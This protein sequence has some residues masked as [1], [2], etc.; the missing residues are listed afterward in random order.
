MSED[1]IKTTVNQIMSEYPGYTK[2]FIFYWMHDMDIGKESAWAISHYNA[3]DDG[4]LQ[5]TIQGASDEEE[6]I[7]KTTAIPKGE[8][9]GRWFDNS[10][11]SENVI[12]IFKENN[13]LKLRQVYS[14]GS[15]GDK[16]LKLQGGK[17]TYPNDFGEYLKIEDTGDLG[18]YDENGIAIVA[19]NIQQ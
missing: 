14:D 10:A 12:T 3:S 9:I 19:K 6:T 18:W 17:Y 1:Q 16:N 13:Q 11:Y 7:M 15:F 5:I 8:I 4:H 2:Y